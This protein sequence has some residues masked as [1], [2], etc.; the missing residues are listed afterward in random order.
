[1]WDVQGRTFLVKNVPGSYE[2][3]I[4]GPDAQ[5]SEGHVVECSPKHCGLVFDVP[6]G[7]TKGKPQPSQSRGRATPAACS[8]RKEDTGRG[9]AGGRCEGRSVTPRCHRAVHITLP[10]GP[11]PPL[12][13]SCGG[14]TRDPGQ[15]THRP[16]PPSGS[17]TDRRY[18]TISSL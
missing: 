4:I 16:Q 10:W 7:Q 1:M 6:M 15:V 2:V 3:R 5:D 9:A 13:S 12:D 18:R 14:H 11:Q 17:C 8:F